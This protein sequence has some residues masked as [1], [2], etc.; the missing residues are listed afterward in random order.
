MPGDGNC[1][2]HALSYGTEHDHH[3]VRARVA[4][5]LDAHWRTYYRDFVP[6]GERVAY[7]RAA[8]RVGEWGDE[9]SLRAFS[10]MMRSPVRVYDTHSRVLLS[11]YGTQYPAPP[12]RVLYNGGH[13]DA[14]VA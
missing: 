6:E 1:L 11:E 9:L 5:Q 3:T 4:S 2:F 14:L 8:R 12:R 10:D 7:R 13:Y